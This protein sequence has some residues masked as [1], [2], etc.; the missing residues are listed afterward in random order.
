MKIIFKTIILI[1]LIFNNS[2]FASDIIKLT[3]V[4]RIP[5]FFKWP[6]Y[7]KNFVIG[8]Y[9]NEDIKN[10]MIDLYKNKNLHGLN[11][12][13][14]NIKKLNDEIL[15]ELNLLYFDKEQINN[16]DSILH[17]I[18]KYPILTITDFPNDVY[19]GMH[20]GFYYE[21]QKIKFLINTDALKLSKLKAS[22]KILRLSKI[23]KSEK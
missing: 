10:K 17:K 13:V 19:N 5:K 23:I 2:I 14:L 3:L 12:K 11:I 15:G 8:V 1:I 9:N 20:I 22:Y 16:E 4:E 18:K 6:N 7:N 21:N